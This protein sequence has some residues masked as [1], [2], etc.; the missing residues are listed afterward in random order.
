MR[1]LRR[2]LTGVFILALTVGLF[3]AAGGTVWSALEARW[4]EEPRQRPSREREFAANVVTFQP[5]TIR[6]VLETFGEVRSRRALEL[7]AATAGEVVWLS[8]AFEEG[9]QVSAGDLLARIDPANAQ[10]A[11]DTARA[12]MTEAEAGLREAQATAALAEAD[13]A[14]AEDQARLRQNALTRQT[15]LLE[16]G[17]GS[18]AAVETAELAASSARQAVL[19]KQQARANALAQV[20]QAAI[21]L[22]RRK[23][24][25]ASW[26]DFGA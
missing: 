12:D 7:R 13:I 14:A 16:R 2:S 24:A 17:V 4:S 10:S 19:T 22:E 21:M 1:F 20:D 25:G 18:A 11:L 8:E 3:A 9:G 26:R 6:P 23:I 15:D 5:E